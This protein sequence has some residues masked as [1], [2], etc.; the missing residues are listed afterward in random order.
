VSQLRELT[1]ET[2]ATALRA[3]G[4]RQDID[5]KADLFSR[6][7]RHL[8]AHGANAD[9]RAYFVPGRIE[10]LGKHTD[11]CGGHS[12]V[13]AV[14]RGICLVAAPREDGQIRIH[15]LDL[16]DTVHFAWDPELDVP[17][18]SW[19]NYPMTVARR[20]ARNFPDSCRGGADIAFAGD[21]PLAS[22]MSSSSALVIAT[23]RALADIEGVEQTS[24]FAAAVGDELSLAEYLG[25]HEN[26][27]SY[28]ALAGDR[29][30]GTFGGS[31][32]HTAILCS[33]PD[34]LGQFSYC[35]TRRK[36]H[37]L[38]PGGWVFALGVSGVVAEKTGA[39]QALY[40]R[41]A[42]RVRRL[43]EAW[44]AAGEG[45]QVYLADILAS[46]PDAG[47]RLRAATIDGHG[48]YGAD[49]LELRLR[50]F[51]AEEALIDTA[52]TEL[53]AGDLPAFGASVSRSQQWSEQMLGNQVPET[54]M[55]AQS[56]RDHGAVAASA[57]GAGFG[58]CVWALIDAAAAPEFLPAWAAGYH[59]GF[60]DRAAASHFF[61]SPAGPSA[62]ELRDPTD[63]PY[64]GDPDPS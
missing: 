6:A 36:R 2:A 30:V 31:E 64:I 17:T 33:Q 13:A 11:Y 9:R 52:A 27:Q 47:Q 3:G 51:E 23:Y 12:L 18:G 44:H 35:P 15:A 62:F 39:A 7:A 55:L 41:A 45:D 63:R 34:H 29:G 42:L 28:G 32:D 24:A 38:V 5:T 48:E 26:G 37:V 10:V 59:A 1:P 25:T 43:V 40:N 49:E 61:T 53:A 57:F 20:L 60:P 4:L 8:T 16:D 14:E 46:A 56:A 50:H 22:G 21:L 54:V 19:P 58:G